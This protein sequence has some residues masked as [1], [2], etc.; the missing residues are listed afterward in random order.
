[1]TTVIAHEFAHQWF[2]DIVTMSWWDD[3]WLNEGFASFVENLGTNYYNSEFNIFDDVISDVDGVL[4]TDSSIYTHKIEQPVNDPNEIDSLFDDITYDKGMS[5]IRMLYNY[6]G[7]R[8]FMNGITAYLRDYVYDNAITVDLWN[9]MNTV[10]D[11][12]VTDMMDNWVNTPGFPLLNVSLNI[13]DETS[14][15]ISL[16]Q[17][18]YMRSG[19]GYSYDSDVINGFDEQIWNI[20]LFGFTSKRNIST[21]MLSTVSD[22]IIMDFDL[23]DKYYMFNRNKNGFFRILYDNTSF[24][25]IKSNFEELSTYDQ[26]TVLSDRYALMGAG[27]I[28]LDG[29]LSFIT[30]IIP[31]LT[32]NAVEKYL[33]WDVVVSTLYIMNNKF[34]QYDSDLSTLNNIRQYGINIL[35]PLYTNLGGWN[36]KTNDAHDLIH[37]RSLVINAL[38]NLNDNDVIYTGL[39]ILEGIINDNNGVMPNVI[40]TNKINS[41]LVVSML[42][43][44][45]A[46][47]KE[48]I[49]NKIM[50]NFANYNAETKG[51][52]LSAIGTV[53]QHETLTQNAIDFILSDAVR[54]NI[55]LRGLGSLNRCT[56][57]FAV[58]TALTNNNGEQWDKLFG[59]FI[60]GFPV[61]DLTSIPGGFITQ[62]MYDNVAA[63]YETRTTSANRITVNQT[64][65]N[66]RAHIYWINNNKVF[67][68]EY[69]DS[70]FLTSTQAPQN[71]S[72][73]K[74]KK[75]LT[76]LIVIL[77]IVG[78]GLLV[79]MVYCCYKR[80][81]KESNESYRRQAN[82]L[83][84]NIASDNDE[85]IGM[86]Y[87]YHFINVC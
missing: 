19:N 6:L 70:W 8:V 15:E 57:K 80:I 49:Y 48:E 14:V 55:K 7:E 78:I 40:P 62:D 58:W 86:L 22:T 64:L 35:K 52:I 71:I 68:R 17:S 47:L 76:G 28:D 41:N 84:N 43:A 50:N 29:F 24:E 54:N 51:H 85:Q 73:P 87:G 45:F 81:N 74:K 79:L 31:Y 27:Y 4:F 75:K 82:E 66:I 36:A 67:I 77:V 63:F 30:E 38:I 23:E 20:P 3:L 16:T 59:I 61:Q 32:Q 26:F 2:G 56:G 12:N 72:E 18:R 5:I 21:D 44:S 9:S 11:V 13:I 83:A 33:C 60:S 42:G 34:C 25:L 46:S 39:S 53:Y 65:E 37:L 69:I 10:T 1:M